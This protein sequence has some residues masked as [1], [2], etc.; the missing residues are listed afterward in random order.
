MFNSKY[1][2][3]RF[4]EKTNNNNK[5]YNKNKLV[6]FTKDEIDIIKNKAVSFDDIQQI[7]LFKNVFECVVVS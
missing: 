4:N 7:K 3:N 2:N 6:V 5:K 1:K